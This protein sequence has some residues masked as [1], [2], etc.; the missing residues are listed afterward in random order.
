[1]KTNRKRCI[2][3]NIQI[4]VDGAQGYFQGSYAHEKSGKTVFSWIAR[5]SLEKLGKV[6]E[7]QEILLHEDSQEK[8]KNL[9]NPCK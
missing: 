1:M 5:K 6:R 3:T 8:V 4:R 2:F 9:Y 7:H